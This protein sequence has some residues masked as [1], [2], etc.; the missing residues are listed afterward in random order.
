MALLLP[1]KVCLT[2]DLWTIHTE[3]EL[4]I[5]Y[6]ETWIIMEITRDISGK[7]QERDIIGKIENMKAKIVRY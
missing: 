2:F 4:F 3:C 1:K 7:R 6:N 5:V